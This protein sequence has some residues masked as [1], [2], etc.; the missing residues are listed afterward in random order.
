M[1]KTILIL[2]AMMGCNIWAQTVTPIVLVCRG[3]YSNS[4]YKQYDVA[5]SNGMIKIS[6][7]S[8]LISG[9]LGFS[10]NEKY[11]I[12]KST[13]DQISFQHSENI[14]FTGAINRYTGAVTLL[15]M[16]PKDD[17]WLQLYQGNCGEQARIF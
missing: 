11:E 14:M 1:P 16:S 5:T 3:A 17:K 6:E 7:A 2:F 8:V 15:N 4:E 10:S 13:A 12:T 9:I